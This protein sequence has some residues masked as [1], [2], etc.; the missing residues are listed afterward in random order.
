[1]VEVGARA[2]RARAAQAQRH[3]D[4]RMAGERQGGSGVLAWLWRKI[5]VRAAETVLYCS[6]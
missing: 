4:W 2:G 3:P 5:R 1:M 6:N